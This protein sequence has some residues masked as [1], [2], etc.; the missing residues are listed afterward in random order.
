MT[1]SRNDL[2]VVLKRNIFLGKQ[3]VSRKNTHTL[4]LVWLTDLAHTHVHV[5][6]DIGG[7]CIAVHRTEQSTSTGRD[8]VL[9]WVRSNV[10]VSAE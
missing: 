8:L 5:R 1:C 10:L 4:S 7:S 9:E 2:P 3:T 6:A